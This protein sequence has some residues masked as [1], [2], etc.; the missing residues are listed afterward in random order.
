MVVTVYA[1]R[2]SVDVASVA[3]G[4]AASLDALS[5]PH[6]VT[7][8]FDR[9]SE[10]ERPRRRRTSTLNTLPANPLPALVNAANATEITILVVWGPLT[11]DLIAAFDLSR[12]VLLVTDDSVSALRAAQRTLKL[13]G[14]LGFGAD[15]VLVVTMLNDNT[16]QWDPAVVATALKR[17]IIGR[18]PR[19]GSAGAT[20]EAYDILCERLLAAAAKREPERL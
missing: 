20:T 14:S 4:L 19:P 10:T 12:I 9:A 13:C 18:V 1:D 17:D 15:R 5:K 16:P 11:G 2:R 8:L 3:Q 7:T 6:Q